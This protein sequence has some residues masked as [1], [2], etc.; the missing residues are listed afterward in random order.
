MSDDNKKKLGEQ[1]VR[2]V[3]DDKLSNDKKLRKMDMDC[4]AY[5]SQ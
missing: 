5:G 3:L 1:L 4:H 2:C